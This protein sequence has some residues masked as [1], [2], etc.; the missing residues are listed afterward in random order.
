MRGITAW[1]LFSD[2]P[3]SGI[4]RCEWTNQGCLIQPPGLTTI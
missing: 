4:E 1:V 3:C 2:Y